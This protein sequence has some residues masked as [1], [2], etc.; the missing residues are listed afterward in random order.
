MQLAKTFVC[1]RASGTFELRFMEPKVVEHVSA[2]ED[3]SL[4]PSRLTF[5]EEL[6]AM[7]V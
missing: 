6:D 3:L 2:D 7:A 1:C 4:D 5:N